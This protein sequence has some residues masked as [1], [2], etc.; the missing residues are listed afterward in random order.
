MTHPQT[1]V[2]SARDLRSST[3]ICHT[4]NL[5]ICGDRACGAVQRKQRPAG[6]AIR[7]KWGQHPPEPAD[8]D[9]VVRGG[10]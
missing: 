2:F 9:D 1:A 3:S 4:N 6:S 10:P 8:P 5:K 7:D